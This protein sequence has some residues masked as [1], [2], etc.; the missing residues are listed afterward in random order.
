MLDWPTLR[1]KLSPEGVLRILAFYVIPLLVVIATICALTMWKSRYTNVTNNVLQLRVLPEQSNQSFTPSSASTLL[2]KAPKLNAYETQRSEYP[3]W[4]SFD[5]E[6]LTQ[7]HEYVEFPSRHAVDVSCW[8]VRTLTVLGRATRDRAEGAIEIVKAGYALQLQR[9]REP[10]MCKAS[11]MG[12]AVLTAKQWSDHGLRTSML[13]NERQSGVLD[14]G[15]I[16]LAMFVCAIA[17]LNKQTIFVLF[18]GWIVLNLR[19]A[20]LSAGWDIQW[21]GYTIPADWLLRIRALTLALYAVSTLTLFQAIFKGE[22]ER[23]RYVGAFKVAEWLCFPL[24]IAALALPYPTF[25]PI[26]W[27]LTAF[28]L[29]LMMASLYTILRKTK[30]RKAVWFSASLTVSFLCSLAEVIAA[31]MGIREVLSFVNSLTAAIASSLLA[32]LALAEQMR[33]DTA[34]RIE[35]QKKLEHAY[36]AM[37]VGLFTLDLNGRFLGW[38]PLLV[39]MLPGSPIVE[40]E[41]TFS[42]FFAD[43]D[44]AYLSELVQAQFDVELQV[45][46]L[47]RSKQFLIKATLSRGKIEG[48]LQD[49]TDQVKANEQLHF[50]A[51]NDPLTK[52]LNRRGI[53]KIY[54]QA[55]V[56]VSTTNPLCLAYLDLDRFKLIND[57]FGHNAGDE[58]LKE[59]CVRVKAEMDV[60]L[61]ANST[62]NYH[63]GRVGGDEFVLVL[64]ATSLALAS[65]ICRGIV[66]QIGGRSYRVGE[67]AFH[68]RGSIG[69][70]EIQSGIPMK[71]AISAADSACVEA[72]KGMSDGLTIYRHN[73]SE[74]RKHEAELDLVATLSDSRATEGLFLEMRP[75]LSLDNPFASVNFEALLHMRQRHGPAIPVEPIIAAAEKSGQAGL[76]DRWVIS[77]TLDWIKANWHELSSTQFICVKL[78]GASLNDERFVQDTIEVLSENQHLTS[79]LCLGIAESVALYDLTNTRRFI[80]QVREAGARI[81]LDNFGAGLTSFS[82]LM[83]CPADVLKIDARFIRNLNSHPANIAVV[84]AIV[85]LAINLGMK[86]IAHG[87]HDADTVETLADLGIDFITDFEGNSLLTTEMQFT[88][89]SAAIFVADSKLAQVIRTIQYTNSI[90]PIAAR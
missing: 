70:I 72:K 40:N 62:C 13:F 69:L 85:S 3:V 49:I 45:A 78:T 81:A 68:V 61:K 39:K 20:A 51:N 19:L 27:A 35:A 59:V 71:D 65:L 76:I 36:E 50:L 56:D 58:V 75:I 63:F 38:N 60:H 41:T 73:A 10:T 23:T 66:D 87:A 84:E 6:D 26:L 9:P 18:A 77:R 67:R 83:E 80:D 14:G 53:E 16:V 8:N 88:E 42:K 4:F 43:E 30:T 37:P 25:L 7:D 89:K 52:A 55:V 44:F 24:L 79:R 17:I 33:D 32:A 12:P 34:Q 82:Y 11:F 29:S 64:P 47:D 54:S 74:L 57:L 21:L 28:G 1:S 15:L 86:T 5:P 48:F 2:T 46:N 31:A 90:K 22:L